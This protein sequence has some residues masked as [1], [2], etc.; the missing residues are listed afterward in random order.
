MYSGAVAT[1]FKY[2]ILRRKV[3]TVCFY[4]QMKYL[5]LFFQ[6]TQLQVRGGKFREWNAKNRIEKS[7]FFNEISSEYK[8]TKLPQN[9]MEKVKSQTSQTETFNSELCNEQ[10]P[11]IY[12]RH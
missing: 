2:F 8:A 1:L 4:R 3:K 12:N 6:K 7:S 10:H 9:Y 5:N 11:I